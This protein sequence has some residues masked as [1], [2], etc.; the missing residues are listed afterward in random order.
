MQNQDVGVGDPV[1]PLRNPEARETA[2]VP[3][4]KVDSAFRPERFPSGAFHPLRPRVEVRD[5]DGRTHAAHLLNISEAGAAVTWPDGVRVPR[6]FEAVHV[7]I[8]FDELVVWD[9]LARAERVQAPSVAVSFQGLI[10]LEAVRQTAIVEAWRPPVDGLANRTWLV[11][12][13]QDIKCLIGDFRLLLEDAR[14]RLEVMEK[15]LP[16]ETCQATTWSPAAAALQARVQSEVVGPLIDLSDQINTAFVAATAGTRSTAVTEK[17]HSFAWRQIGQLLMTSPFMSRALEKPL[18][19][20]GDY[21]LMNYIYRNRFAGDSLFARAVTL[22]GVSNRTGDAVFGR[23]DM[24]RGEI[25]QL[26]T[27]RAGTTEPV[28]ILAVAAGPAEEMWELL[29]GP[30]P[31]DVP[32]EVVLFEQ[33]ADALGFAY[34]RLQAARAN[35]R[36]ANVSIQF[37]KDNVTKLI[38]GGPDHQDLDRY[39]AVF[40]CGLFDYFGDPA[41]HRVARALASCVAPGGTL[42][43]GNMV[44]EASARWFMELHLNWFLHYRTEGEILALARRSAPGLDVRIQRDPTGI[45]PFARFERA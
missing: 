10:D 32:V 7:L 17:L 1:Q 5:G 27:D 9:G 13:Y 12:G 21:L 34:R 35:G 19:Y 26:L 24:I 20:P 18:G 44:P 6:R 38:Y 39:D 16:R 2:H 11:D 41:W 28:R 22:F 3:S 43:I 37:R 23:K 33:D 4:R 14:T 40:S 31:I 25:E 45:N 30:F 36:R 42:W 8:A 29:S 15:E